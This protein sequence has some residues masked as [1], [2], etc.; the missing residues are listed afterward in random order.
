MSTMFVSSR[1]MAHLVALTAAEGFPLHAH[2]L[3]P[4]LAGLRT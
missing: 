3:L 2:V 4:L 1:T